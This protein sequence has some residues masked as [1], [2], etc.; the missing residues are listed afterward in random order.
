[1]EKI[2]TIEFFRK[3]ST[4]EELQDGTAGDDSKTHFHVEKIIELTTAEYNHF[5]MNLLQNHSFLEN[6]K[7]LM[8][9]GEDDF[10][11]CLFVTTGTQVD[12]ILVDSSGYSHARYAAYVD[13]RDRLELENVPVEQYTLQIKQPE[14]E[15]KKIT[16][17][18]FEHHPDDIYDLGY[19]PDFEEFRIEKVIELSQQDY[20]HFA[21]NLA[22][23][24]SFIADN[25]EV[26][27]NNMPGDVRHC[28]FITTSDQ[29]DGILVDSW[30]YDHA[31]DAA[32]LERKEELDLASAPVEQYSIPNKEKERPKLER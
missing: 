4:L 18:I 17:A 27:K 15:P 25:R 8:H 5:T 16:A 9:Y 23:S 22:R 30:G 19:I 2:E 21:D 31:V 12:G 29:Q 3:A 6:N 24:Y 11:H 14:P 26:M 13:T 7:N 28:L 32:Y 10:R 20:E 1:M